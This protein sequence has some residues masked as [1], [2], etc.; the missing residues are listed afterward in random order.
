MTTALNPVWLWVIS[1]APSEFQP[2]AG[3]W[4]V[5][6]GIFVQ[7]HHK[8]SSAMQGTSHTLLWKGELQG[9]AAMARAQ[10]GES[11]LHHHGTPVLQSKEVNA[12]TKHKRKPVS[13]T[14]K[15]RFSPLHA[16][17]ESFTGDYSNAIPVLSWNISS[18][19]PLPAK[20]TT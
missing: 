3:R 7:L 2:P 19:P 15:K 1:P 11:F 6:R 20:K 5:H 12:S 16:F 14:K 4:A 8:A 13:L 10:R 18:L 17:T 9:Q